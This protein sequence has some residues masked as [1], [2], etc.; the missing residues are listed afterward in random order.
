MEERGCAITRPDIEALKVSVDQNWIDMSD[1]ALST[2]CK[3]FC[4][5]LE[6]RISAN[7]S[8]FEK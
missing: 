7:G 8:F 5:R 2:A 6:K 1:A 4:G 3:G